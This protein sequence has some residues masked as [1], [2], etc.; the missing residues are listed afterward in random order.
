MSEYLITL[1]PVNK[2][3][4]GGDMTFQVGGDENNTYNEQYASYIIESNKFPQQTSLLGMLRFLILKNSPCFNGDQITEKAGAKRLI[5][6]TSFRVNKKHEENDFGCIKSI[7]GCFLQLKKASSKEWIDLSFA[8]FDSQFNVRKGMA[9]GC[10]NKENKEIPILEGFEAKNGYTKYMEAHEIKIP[11]SDIFVKDRRLG[12]NRNIATGKT[13]NDGLFK[14]I[15]YCLT[16]KYYDYNDRGERIKDKEGKEVESACQFRYAFKAN[17][18]DEDQD[19]RLENYNGHLVS[20]GGDNSQFVIGIGKCPAKECKKTEHRQ[21]EYEYVI[22]LQS[23]AYLLKKEVDHACF[24]ITEIVPFRFL[25]T[26]VEGTTSYNILHR[27]IS[28]SVRY[29]LY[30]RGSVFY[31][32]EENAKNEFV[33]ALKEKKEFVQIGYNQFVEFINNKEGNK[34]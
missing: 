12:I 31:F 29:Q 15:S 4:F 18:S 3:F 13:D 22:V 24:A 23:P 11:I 7:L 21:N 25:E 20:I 9:T 27:G 8:P 33:E 2:F 32:S 1:T 30:D 19:W 26:S 6:A 34:Q 17:I 10:Y 28:R 16:D 5:G 14:Q